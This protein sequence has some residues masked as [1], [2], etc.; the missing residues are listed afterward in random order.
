MVQDDHVMRAGCQT[1]HVSE[2]SSTGSIKT[3]FLL[4]FPKRSSECINLKTWL[5]VSDRTALNGCVAVT[6]SVV[7]NSF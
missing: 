2:A 1:C 7:F 3:N 4:T 6:T 5:D